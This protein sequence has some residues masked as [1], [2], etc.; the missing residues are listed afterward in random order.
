MAK[1]G[2]TDADDHIAGIQLLM[3][4]EKNDSTIT[5]QDCF[6]LYLT[7]RKFGGGSADRLFRSFLIRTS[8]GLW[9]RTRGDVTELILVQHNY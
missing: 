6:V 9:G 4:K 5:W 1:A 8:A 7:P 3:R 2:E